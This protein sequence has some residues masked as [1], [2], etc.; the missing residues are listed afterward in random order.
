MGRAIAAGGAS[1]EEIQRFQNTYRVQMPADLCRYFR[2]VNGMR[3]DW[4]YDQDSNGF[5][6]WT[7]S[8]VQPLSVLMPSE[9]LEWPDPSL[10]SNDMQYFV[11]ADYLAE[12]W[13]YAIGLANRAYT[14]VII[15]GPLNE[16]VAHSFSEF[17]DLY[18]VDSRKL[19]P[20]RGSQH[21]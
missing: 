7:L 16:L 21:I 19:Y 2:E 18:F 14:P 17:L 11:F 9:S 5:T 8:M 13:H 12:C 6:F 4:R 15:I 10:N 1:E 3:P 20:S